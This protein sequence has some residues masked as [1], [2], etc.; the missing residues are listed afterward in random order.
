MT[1]DPDAAAHADAGIFGLDTTA[2]TA[3]IVLIPVPFDATTSYRQGASRGPE[4]IFAASSQVDLY[5][6]DTGRPYEAGIFMLPTPEKI[7]DLNTEARRHVDSHRQGDLREAALARVN[8]IGTEVNAW[9]YAET[10]KII[11]QGRIA[12]L[13][14]GDHATPFGCIK[15]H[16]EAF[17]DVGI[18]HIDAHADL[19]VAYEGFVWSHAS[20]MHNVLTHTPVKKIVQVGIRDFAQSEYDRIRDSGG[21]IVTFFDRDLADRQFEGKPFAETIRDIVA[22]LPE[23][24]YVSFDIDG[25]DPVLCPHIVGFD[26]TEVAPGPPGDE[27]DGNVG[28]RVLYKLCGHA[29]LGPKKRPPLSTSMS[30]P[31]A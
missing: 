8:A 24:V 27:W 30:L 20:I 2:D 6:I 3:G 23:E 1:F 16:V 12:G 19:R 15:A 26:L 13:V 4:A 31:A 11:R 5:D 21:R 7:V 10:R 25:L 17:A 14:G 9:V 22:E 18:L 28:A 29:L